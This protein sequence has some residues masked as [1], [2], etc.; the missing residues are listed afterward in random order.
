MYFSQSALAALWLY[1]FLLGLF[2]G[3]V[4]DALRIT[5]IFLGASY[6]P[7]LK[8]KLQAVTLP[9]L[10]K[11]VRRIKRQGVFFWIF[12]FIGD[13]LFSL[14]GGV[15]LI[16][17]FYQFNSGK[18]RF[19]AFFCTGVGFFLYRKTLGRLVMLL[20]EA[21]AFV[22]ESA[23]RYLCFFAALPFRALFGVIWRFAVA[24]HKKAKAKKQ[25]KERLRQTKKEW[26]KLTAGDKEKK[27][28]VITEEKN[29][30]R[31]KKAV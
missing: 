7:R 15:L 16:L 23:V 31:I 11:R 5:R 9:F 28:E 4:Y 24:K 6:S 14:L 13:L 20:S 22:L 29:G 12:V 30:E 26:Q 3:A 18:I 17:L 8:E 19:P 21:I 25:R 1:A 10:K 27:Q 2:L